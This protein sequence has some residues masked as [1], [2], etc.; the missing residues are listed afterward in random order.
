MSNFSAGEIVKTTS[1]TS[2]RLEGVIKHIT[3]FAATGSGGRTC[4][5]NKCAHTPKTNIWVKWP[6]GKL[7]SYGFNELEPDVDGEE[8]ILQTMEDMLDSDDTEDV[9]NAGQVIKT[10]NQSRRKRVNSNPSAKAVN[11]VA[12]N[13]S[14]FGMV[15]SD[16]TNA[17]Y[18]V[19]SKQINNGLRNAIVDMLKSRGANNSQVEGIAAFL[20]TEW[21]S[22][23]IGMAAGYGLTYVPMIK[24]NPKAQRLAQEFRVAGM[25][26]VGNEVVSSLVDQFLPIFTGALSSLPEETTFSQVTEGSKST[27]QKVDQEIEVETDFSA[28]E[29]RLEEE[30]K[31]L[32][33]NGT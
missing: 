24:D 9:Y 13:K 32:V 10:I 11:T 17:A 5:R 1:T 4:D 28:L 8:D 15:K 2:D 3:C 21:G 7:C 25:A 18:R 22:A 29:K 33:Q 26:T 31:E 19:A 6:N 27:T 12:D 30:E 16:A 23:F 14:L 20:D